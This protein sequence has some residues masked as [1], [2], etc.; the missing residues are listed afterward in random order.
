MPYDFPRPVVQSFEGDSIGFEISEK[1]TQGLKEIALSE[2]ATLFMVLLAIYNVL[3]FKMSG[4]EDIVVG[5]GV[6]GRQHAEFRDIIGMFVN[7]LALRNYPKKDK[8]FNAFLQEVRDN[9]LKAYENQDYQY[10]TL[11]DKVVLNRELNRN[12][13]FD[14]AFVLQNVEADVPGTTGT[15]PHGLIAKPYN[16]EHR[17]SR[18]DMTFAVTEINGELTIGIEYSTK[19]FEKITIMKIIDYFKRIVS[20][21]LADNQVLLKDITLAREAREADTEI[22]QYEFQL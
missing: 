11:V 2:E 4:Q 17:V 20:T 7:T 22:P 13:L 18:F 19:L 12:P 9:T 16:T 6:A 1:E 15:G 10:E 8:T 21:V 5:T 3:L 14:T